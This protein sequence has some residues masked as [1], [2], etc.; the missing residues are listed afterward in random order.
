M[1]RRTVEMASDSSVITDPNPRFAMALDLC[2][3]SLRGL[4]QYELDESL[5]RRLSDLGARKEF[6]DSDEHDELLSLVSFA[7]KRTEE[8]LQAQLALRRLGEFLPDLVGKN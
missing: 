4:A 2:V 7:E 1:L 6:L 8:K 5:Q 3:R